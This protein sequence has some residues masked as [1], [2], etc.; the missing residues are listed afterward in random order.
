MFLTFRVNLTGPDSFRIGVSKLV[1]DPA[2]LSCGVFI[3]SNTLVAMPAFIMLAA[4]ISFDEFFMNFSSKAMLFDIN[5]I[6]K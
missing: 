3:E 1:M 6:E 4:L 2:G 5:P